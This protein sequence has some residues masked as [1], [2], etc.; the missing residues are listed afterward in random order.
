MSKLFGLIRLLNDKEMKAIHG[1]SVRILE[2]IG[3]WIDSL[4][5]LDYLAGYGCIVDKNKMRV[6]FPEKVVEKAINVLKMKSL[7]QE[8]HLYHDFGTKVAGFTRWVE[9]IEG[10]IKLATFKECKEAICLGDALRNITDIG[11]PLSPQ[12]IPPKLRPI[13]MAATLVQYTQKFG[14]IEAWSKKDVDFLKEIALVVRENEIELKNHPVFYG[15]SESRTP[16]CIDSVMAEVFIEY[17][18]LNFPVTFISMPCSGSTAPVTS[19]GTLAVSI[20]EILAGLILGYAINEEARVEIKIAPGVMDM[21]SMLFASSGPD[22]IDLSAATIQMI[23]SFYGLPCYCHAGKTTA[24]FSGV[25]AGYEKALS[26]LLPILMGAQGV[27]PVGQ[28]EN[29][30]VFSYTQLVIDDEI[31][32]YIKRML[33]G[34]EVSD[35]NTAFEVIKEVGI[36][37]NFL[38]HNH[39]LANFKKEL[40]TS[41]LTERMSKEL[42]TKE[43][44]KGIEEKA[45]D[46]A[47]KILQNKPP[48]YLDKNQI[49]EIE[50]IV[51]KAEGVLL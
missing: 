51:K 28:F 48:N 21:R 19:A 1:T 18:Y 3:C 37:G 31:I 23:S 29:S 15:F 35:D 50:R 9:D 17:V 33:K 2:E 39:T 44:H 40:W 7:K 12:E 43:V 30:Q 10:R 41:D 11:I 6:R 36:G 26:I 5:A 49:N 38:T 42:W 16:L 45:R 27:G 32:T 25:Q 46:K 34:F 14:T 13:K 24:N 4:E 47:K 22:K 20:A 8:N